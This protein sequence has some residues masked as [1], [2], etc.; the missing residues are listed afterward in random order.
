MKQEII[1]VSKIT[2]RDYLVSLR[3]GSASYVC[4][5]SDLTVILTSECIIHFDTRGGSAI[6]DM[7]A[8]YGET[9]N[10]PE[11]PTREG[12]Y[13]VGWYKDIDL[14]EAWNFETD[15]VES[16]M[17][18]FAKWTDVA[19]EMPEAADDTDN[20]MLWLLL[21]ILILLLLLLF[22]ARKTVTFECGE[23]ITVEPVKVFYGKLLP[24]PAD[25]VKE[26]AVFGGWYQNADGTEAWNFET[27][28][29]KANITLYAHWL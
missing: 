4:E 18:L 2:N 25:P 19:P 12:M 14:K 6:P 7:V 21:L 13:F 23:G 3:D 11:N 1:K 24:K 29:V 17:T 15:I 5:A 20:S 28:K 22:L 16:N 10:P 9:I 26:G 27:D 8:V